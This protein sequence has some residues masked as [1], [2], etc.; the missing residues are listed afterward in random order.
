LEIELPNSFRENVYLSEVISSTNFLKK[1]IKLPIALEKSI[2][3]IPIVGDLNSVPH[4][5]NCWNYW[6]R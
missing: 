4:L 5:L 3:G 1:K 2:S 6:I